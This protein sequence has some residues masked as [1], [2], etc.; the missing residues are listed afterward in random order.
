[1]AKGGGESCWILGGDPWSQFHKGGGG[2]LSVARGLLRLGAGGYSSRGAARLAPWSVIPVRFQ[3]WGIHSGDSRRG[4]HSAHPWVLLW[5]DS[6][7]LVPA[8]QSWGGEGE[9][10]LDPGSDPEDLLGICLERDLPCAGAWA[11]GTAVPEQPGLLL[12]SSGGSLWNP[13]PTPAGSAWDLPGEGSARRCRTAR[14]QRS[15]GADPVRSPLCGA[16]GGSQL[17]P[18]PLGSP[19]NLPRRDPLGAD[20]RPMDT[21]GLKQP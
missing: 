9:F 17:D 1:M 11:G 20:S 7:A 10:L 6:P 2:G 19:R 15:L 13:S 3:P 21:A 16:P 14:G 8:Q 4:I 5:E 12:Q 18:H